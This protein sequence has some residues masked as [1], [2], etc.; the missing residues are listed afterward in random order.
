MANTYTQIHLHLVF[1]VKY[2]RCLIQA[3]WKDALYKYMTGVVQN[4]G[5]KLL[6]IN[7]VQDHVHLL[8]G[9]RPTQ[10]LSDLMRDVK[11]MSSKWVNENHLSSFRF[12]WQEGYG[13]FS[14]NKSLLPHVIRYIEQQEQHHRKKTFLQEYRQ[15]LD[16]F[17]VDYDEKYLFHLPR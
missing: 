1:A 17:E 13:A 5:H 2:R 6:I 8:V 16:E 7:G 3:A 12:A 11:Q 15:L 10:A 4:N 9:F 14:Y